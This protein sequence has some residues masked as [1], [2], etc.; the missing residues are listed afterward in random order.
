MLDKIPSIFKT[1]SKSFI[2]EFLMRYA[3]K[4]IHYVVTLF[5]SVRHKAGSFIEKLFKL[6][7]AIIF[8]SGLTNESG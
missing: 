7:L 6:N 4:S 8:G 1:K 5:W 3:H 2:R